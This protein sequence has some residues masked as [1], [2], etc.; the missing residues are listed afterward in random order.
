MSSKPP[1][2]AVPR[3]PSRVAGRLIAPALAVLMLGACG[4]L[5]VRPSAETAVVRNPAVAEAGALARDGV[6]LTGQ[7]RVD[8]V[9]RIRQLLSQL[10]NDTLAREA[11]ALAP[12][13][14]LYNYLGRA[15]LERGLP[16]PRPFDHTAWSF[17]A[18]NR[19]PAESDGYRPPVKLALLLPLSGELAIAAAPVRDGF[20]AGFY[21][22]HRRRP[23]VVFY[24]TT[25]ST[26]G[27]LSAY[28]RAV[29]EGNDF[30]VGP[31][32]RAAVDALFARG[33]MPVS[34]LALNSGSES[35]P[36]GSASFALAPEDEGIA[37]AE[38]LLAR[39]AT[40]VLVVAGGEDSQRRAVDALRERLGERGAAVSDV[41]GEGIAD[42]A[43]FTERDG[44]RVDG[45]FL[46][47]R[48]A[49]ARGLAPKLALAGLGTVPRVATSQLLSGTG[50]AAEDR[51]L[52]GIAFP[53]E[54]WT[55]RGVTGLPSAGFAAEMLPTARG[56]A[57]RLFAFGY[58]AWLLSAYMER[59]V[60][61]TD[62][63][64]Q[65][66]TGSLQ[67]DGFGNVTRTPAWATFVSGVVMPLPGGDDRRGDR[68]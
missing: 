59:L 32:D 1:A 15:L 46:A 6:V 42:L 7:A 56:A 54:A 17:D 43:P 9:R 2:T 36:A 34:L 50:D 27:T 5:G 37:A 10:D 31:L 18:N 62:G 14:P 57:A 66:A 60:K 22:E 47:M 49:A 13:D 19:P 11:A 44:A 65:G 4:G 26:A 63:T 40:R 25:G 20:M 52:D 8:N 48:G 35:P 41:V 16:L 68:L 28:D 3:H 64:I 67:L 45:V 24:D 38:Y 12:A 53:T 29:T 23:E 39:G 51:A 33:S 58:D 61:T 21:G 30:I 55:A